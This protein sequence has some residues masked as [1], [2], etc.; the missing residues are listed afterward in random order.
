[1]RRTLLLAGVALA[2]ATPAAAAIVPRVVEF[3]PP[4]LD[5]T[6]VPLPLNVTRPPL[7]PP[8]PPALSAP[9]G[10]AGGPALPRFASLLRKP[11]P[12]ADN[13]SA[14]ACTFTFGRPAALVECG[15]VRVLQDDLQG[16]RD[17]LEDALRRDSRGPHTARAYLWLGEVAWRQRRFDEAERHFLTALRVSP[18]A[19]LIPHATLGAAWIALYRGD[20]ADAQ[21]LLA[22]GLG[23]PAP[24]EVALLLRFEDGV[25]RLLQGQPDAALTAWQAVAGAGP[26]PE[27]TEEL[28]FWR[29]VALARRDQPDGALAAL[30]TFLASASAGHPLRHDALIQ[31]GWVAL[32]RGV[33][34]D[35]VRRLLLA[36]AAGPRPELL[37]QLRAGLARA[38]L[39]LG[40]PARARDAARLL[41]A[42]APR[43]PARV[44]VL[45]LLAEDALRRQATAEAVDTLR[46]LLALPVD[47]ALAEYATFR[48]AEGVERLGGAAEA[49]R[50]YRRLSETG[51][52]EAVAQRA[53]ARLGL[54]ALRAG[55]PADARREGEG[56]LRAGVLAELREAVLLLTAE[57][58][59]RGDDAN[60]A[61]VLFRA[62]LHDYPASPHAAAARVA[63]G[64]ALYRDREPESALR[65]WEEARLAADLDVAILAHL[66]IAEV[67][68]RQG[69]EEQSLAA[70]QAL[71][72]LAPG[73]PLADTLALN[74]GILL[75]RAKQ[76]EPA[77]QALEPLTV[78]VK[79]PRL[80][81]ILRRGLAIARYQLQQ[82]DAAERE[83][84]WARYW[85]PAEPSNSLGEGLAALHQ[86]RLNEAEKAL[87]IARFAAA[88]EVAI[89]ATYGLVVAAH[90]RRDPQLFRERATTFVERYPADAYSTVILYGLVRQ[91]VER[92]ELARAHDTLNRLLR[93][94]PKS[95]LVPDALVL[96]ADAA[97]GTPAVARQV[98]AEILARLTDPS[99]RADTWLRLGEA[100]LALRDGPG[101]E[102]ALEGFLREAPDHERAV[103]ALVLLVQAAELQGQQDRVVVRIEDVLRRDPTHPFAPQMQL[104]RGHY[105]LVAQQWEQARVALEAARDTGEPPVAARAHVYL[106]QLL[107]SRGEHEDAVVAYLGAAYLYPDESA[108]AA[109]G[110]QGAVQSYLALSKAREASILLRKLL[111]RPGVERD[112]TDWA[113]DR[114]ARLGPI[115]GEDPAQ[116]LRKGPAR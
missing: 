39:A 32:G 83:F 9:S 71:G 45:F 65:E 27:M 42:D 81:A 86:N 68:R 87:G 82:F 47:P 115:T 19:P 4:P 73:H 79:E 99:T 67:A 59:A 80:Q 104:T 98:Y 53:G 36:Q 114:L 93:E 16:A 37:A 38:Y 112:V 63:L 92:Q 107:R 31:A 54:L 12:P 46:Q 41:G 110:L 2:L 116:V 1:M 15:V 108:W 84:G 35:A 14:T 72:R 44:G 11:A 105:Y 13:P 100:S 57:S 74:R 29:G 5:L 94:Q 55:R 50:H 88:P 49:E 106:G 70:L 96:V 8:A 76:Y 97:R 109:R 113:R 24:P 51:R 18:P 33:P 102:R 89:P 95:E 64:W 6:V 26:P 60:R 75:V 22:Q 20:V 69:H 78:R 21:R 30:D 90:R 23:A 91:A 111:A 10:H 56:L 77:V 62:V 7:E 103:D 66:A 52:V 34:D 28:H 61:V 85:A 43:D 17:A 48:L 25:A 58:A 101:A 40:D 3:P